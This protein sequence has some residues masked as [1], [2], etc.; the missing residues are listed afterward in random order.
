MKLGVLSDIHGNFEALKACIDYLERRNVDAY[1]FLGDYVGEFPNPEM[2]LGLIYGLMKR[3]QCFIIRGNKEEYVLKGIGD[4]HPEWDEYPSTVG[5]LRYGYRHS[6]DKEK[7]FFESLPNNMVIKLDGYA[8][9]RI[10]HGSPFETKGSVKNCTEE[11]LSKLDEKYILCGHTHKASAVY[12][13]G[14]KIW[15]PGSVGLP[16]G[17][18]ESAQ[19]MILYGENGE[20]RPDYLEIPYDIDKEIDSMKREGLFRIAPCWS[21]VTLDL[22]KGGTVSHGAVLDYA[23]KLCEKENGFCNWPQVP[24]KYMH[25]AV[26]ELV[27][28]D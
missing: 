23:M 7:A 20:W 12:K 22:L 13:Y 17:G 3:K 21:L 15:N 24:E 2:T 10:C 9:I 19:C 1:I 6:T 4:G 27:F 11:E 18:E 26:S 16:L 14:K 28:L 8:P 5:M 25:K